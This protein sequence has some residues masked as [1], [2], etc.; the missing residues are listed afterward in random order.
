MWHGYVGFQDVNLNANQRAT[1]WDVLKDLPPA[2][3]TGQPKHRN[4]WIVSLD[5]SKAICELLFDEES[6][7]IAGI[8][9]K[10]ANIFNVNEDNIDVDRRRI[11]LGWSHS[12]V[13]TFSYNGTNYLR[14]IVFGG[15]GADFLQSKDACMDYFLQNMDDW[16]E[17][18]DGPD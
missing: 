14:V 6:I 17:P 3:S 5:K 2:L 7:S 1:L 18:G 16:K 12:P 13:W 11:E 10:L 9:R 4:Q 15:I 8:T